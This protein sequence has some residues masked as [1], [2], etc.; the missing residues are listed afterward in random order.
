MCSS[1]GTTWTVFLQA[2]SSHGISTRILEWVAIFPPKALPDRDELMS[3][4]SHCIGRRILLLGLGW[5]TGRK[6]IRGMIHL[7]RAASLVLIDQD[8][9]IIHIEDLF[10]KYKKRK[11]H[12]ENYSKSQLK[13]FSE[14]YVLILQN[15]RWNFWLDCIQMVFQVNSIIHT[16]VH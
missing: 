3:L 1:L 11:F 2:H 13:I 5:V 14:K 8:L 6:L 9:Q 4:A 15:T 12:F 7:P 16:T 10:S